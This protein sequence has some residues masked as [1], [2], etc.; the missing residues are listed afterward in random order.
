MNIDGFPFEGETI[1]ARALK[2]GGMVY[3]EGQIQPAFQSGCKTMQELVR[4]C[5]DRVAVNSRR[6]HLAGRRASR[7]AGVH[8]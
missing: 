7:A 4:F 5:E 2:R 1:T 8:L 6:S 3:S